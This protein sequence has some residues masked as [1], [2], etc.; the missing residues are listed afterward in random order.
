MDLHQPR[1]KNW[2]LGG[3]GG[4]E[5]RDGSSCAYINISITILYVLWAGERVSLNQTFHLRTLEGHITLPTVLVSENFSLVGGLVQ[6]EHV[7]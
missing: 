4:K 2:I 7:L 5:D 3:G 1:S 6:S